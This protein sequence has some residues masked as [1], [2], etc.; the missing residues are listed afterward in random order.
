MSNFTFEFCQML[1]VKSWQNHLDLLLSCSI[2]S[3]SRSACPCPL[4]LAWRTRTP[5]ASVCPVLR[6]GESCLDLLALVE[7]LLAHVVPVVRLHS[8]RLV[9]HFY[10]QIHWELQN[11]PGW[12]SQDHFKRTFLKSFHPLAAP[13]AIAAPRC[14]TWYCWGFPNSPR[15]HLHFCFEQIPQKCKSSC[16]LDS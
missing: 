9:E 4:L 5:L 14:A 10:L 12:L 11:A 2:W 16:S 1:F 8:N 6:E 3:S 15:N 7:F 13:G